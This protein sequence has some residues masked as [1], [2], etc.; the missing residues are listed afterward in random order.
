MNRTRRGRTFPLGIDLGTRRL[1]VAL[2]ERGADDRPALV[3]VA[4][5]DHDGDTAAALVDAVTE[6]GSAERRCVFG[7]GEPRALLRNVRFP[8]M[9]R[10][11][12]ERAARF[13][14]EGFID[15]PITDA[16]VRVVALGSDG[17]TMIGVVRK[18]VIAS[19]VTIAHAAQLRVN[20][21]DNN[22]F[23][24]RRALP[25]VDAVLDI[26][27][28][29][30]RLH[31]FTGATPVSRRF[32]TGGAAFTDAVANAFGTD[33]ATA[34]RRKQSLGIAGC[35][36]SALDGLVADVASALVDCRA[37][38]LGDVRTMALTGNGSRLVELPALIERA[39]AVRVRTAS[40]D[41]AISHTLPPD[42]L[43]AAAPDWSLAYGLALWS[44]P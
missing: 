9:R 14:A 4:A 31:V 44:T 25:D 23:A 27:E 8:A 16:I 19:L 26:G 38:G 41:P 43:R 6:I 42:V 2:V 29:D 15:Y 18:D 32:A 7:L 28:A 39:T 24:L 20:G 12:H 10:A 21:V 33:P 30:S 11:E 22:A 34:E 13:E 40:L 17:G 3:A 36:G 35:A 5:R 1:R 37:D